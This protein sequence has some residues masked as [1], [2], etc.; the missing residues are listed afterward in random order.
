MFADLQPARM[1]GLA[2]GSVYH[3]EIKSTL[4]HGWTATHRWPLAVEPACLQ[5]GCG[6]LG[7]M[8]SANLGCKICDC[9]GFLIEV[10]RNKIKAH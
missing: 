5:L 3:A 10:L 9:L 1:T 4:G 7:H 6:R 2:E 8:D